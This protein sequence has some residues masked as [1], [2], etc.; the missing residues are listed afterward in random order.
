MGLLIPRG[1][2]TTLSAVFLVVFALIAGWLLGQKNTTKL[3]ALAFFMIFWAV[4]EL[5][6]LPYTGATLDAPSVESLYSIIALVTGRMFHI[7]LVIFPLSV[8]YLYGKTYSNFLEGLETKAK[9]HLAKHYLRKPSILVATVLFLGFFT[10]LITP[11]TTPPINTENSIAELTSIPV[12]GQNQTLLIRGHNKDNPVLF[13]LA[14]GPGGTDIGAMRMF[15]SKLEE[16][17]I[18]VTWDQRGVGKSYSSIEPT[19]NFTLDQTVKDT[20]EVT[21]YLR[22]RFSKDKVFILGNSWGTILGALAVEQHPEL[23]YA[24]ISAGQMVS[25]KETDVMFYEDTLQWA[26]ATNNK[27]LEDQ[28]FTNGPPPYKDY[29]KYEAAL[30]YE[31]S[32]NEFPYFTGE[33]EMSSTL[34]ASEYSLIDKF[35]TF[36]A[37][38]DTFT[39]FYPQ[40]QD[41]DLRSQVTDLNVPIFMIQGT[42]EARGR[43][44]LADEW[45]SKVKAPHKERVEFNKS[46]H[47]PLFEEP[48]KFANVMQQVLNK[49]KEL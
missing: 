7:F 41:I 15:G 44:V 27:A 9:Q 20:I 28:L 39:I 12:G 30:S 6:R 48:E 22:E 29:R 43:A 35:H 14:G 46:A 25:I 21:N 47:R 36:A 38:L 11:A 18:V 1:P 24:Y 4:Y 33:S 8:G 2:L 49:T 16:Q 40:L 32:W 45:F 17:F 19:S 13:H 31:H 5:T 26:R 23:Y 3:N 10:L 34:G 37:F 42:Y